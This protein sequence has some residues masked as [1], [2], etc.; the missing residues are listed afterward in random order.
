MRMV[1]NHVLF[2]T[3]G[4]LMKV[5]TYTIGC[6]VNQYETEAVL[7]MFLNKGYTVVPFSEKADVYIINTCSVT[8]M[9]DAKNRQMIRKCHRLNPNAVVAVMGC[10]S[11]VA[12]DEVAQIE[13]V[14]IVIGTQNRSKLLEMAEELLKNK[15]EANEPTV[16]V[17]ATDFRVELPFEELSISRFEGHT[18]AFIKI[19]DGCSQFC[20]YCIIPYARG[21]V[22]SRTLE[23][24]RNEVEKVANMGFLEVVLVGIHLASY[25]KDLEPR[26]T[27]KDAVSAASSVKKIKRVRLGSL[28]PMYLSDEVIKALSEN[29]KFCRHFHLSLQSGS[30]SVLKRMNRKYTTDEYMEIVDTIRKYMPDCAITTDVMVGF[31]G[32]TEEE[33]LESLEFVRSVGF[34]RIHVFPFSPRKGTVAYKMK[35]QIE[36]S[37]K[38]ERVDRMIAL[39]MDLEQRFLGSMTGKVLDVL[40]EKDCVGYTGNYVKVVVNEEDF[41]EGELILVRITGV[42]GNECIGE[43]I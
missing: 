5:A 8:Q 10:Y 23:S 17:N 14:D 15:K 20:S 25:G 1:D 13:G 22:R 36:N 12:P 34:S 38:K 32:E 41:K 4:V 26:V 30:D 2:I 33:F 24:L 40:C 28:D 42:T 39:G 43:R 29:Q 9:S 27:L 35:D 3:E 6:K 21:P 7:E 37:V 18:R 11:Q 31:P 16:D 19:Q